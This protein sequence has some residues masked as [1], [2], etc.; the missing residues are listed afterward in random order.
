MSLRKLMKLAAVALV[1]AGPAMADE[2]GDCAAST[3]FD[4]IT[5]TMGHI[6]YTLLRPIT[7]YDPYPDFVQAAEITT[8]VTETAFKTVVS[9]SVEVVTVVTTTTLGSI[10]T[11]TPQTSFILGLPAGVE[12]RDVTT[13]TVY[14]Y[15]SPS[16]TDGATETALGSGPSTTTVSAAS[17]TTL[18]GTYSLTYPSGLLTVTTNPFSVLSTTAT[19]TLATSTTQGMSLS[20][21]AETE[22]TA[23]SMS[24]S[25]SV[26]ASVS[27]SVPMSASTSIPTS[28]SISMS[29]ASAGG[30]FITIPFSSST[31]STQSS[32][33]V[34]AES[35]AS[36][37]PSKPTA[38][39]V[40]GSGRVV[41][42]LAA[43]AIVLVFVI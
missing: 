41:P 28:I 15:G 42:A 7:T 23:I 16:A 5:R 26:P 14:G 6:T 32:Q 25:T 29:S 24:V 2:D 30:T 1:A 36:P 37:A 22:T 17:T 40:S 10:P 38:S 19:P 13:V 34:P 4:F 31:V 27:A 35:E 21:S 20:G 11:L 18:M 39:L 9:T 33:T 3:S 8:T 43:V 12:K